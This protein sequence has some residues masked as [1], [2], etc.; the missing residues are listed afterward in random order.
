LANPPYLSCN[1]PG[2]LSTEK[3]GVSKEKDYSMAPAGL[4]ISGLFPPINFS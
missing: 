3:Y 2:N 1:L 4:T